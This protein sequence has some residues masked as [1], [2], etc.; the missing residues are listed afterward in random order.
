MSIISDGGQTRVAAKDLGHK[1]VNVGVK[2][3]EVSDKVEEIGDKVDDVDDKVQYI[4]KKVQVVLDG[5]R[6][7]SSQLSNPSN[8]YIFRRQASKRSGE[9]HR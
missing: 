1:V 7:L 5:A 4:D 9:G 6:G 8:I 3:E 2:V